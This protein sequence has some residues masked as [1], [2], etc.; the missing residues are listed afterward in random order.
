[1]EVVLRTAAEVTA[2]DA[3]GKAVV[4]VS[5]SVSSRVLGRKLAEVSNGAVILEPYA[6]DDMGMTGKV[7]ERSYGTRA[8]QKA[9]RIGGSH[10]LAAGRTGRTVVVNAPAR[11]GWG[12]PSKSAVIAAT[13]E[14]RKRSAVFGYDVGA[15]MVGAT[16]P[17][18]RVGW[19]ATKDVPTRLNADGWALFDAAV[20]WA[21]GL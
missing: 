15:V 10:P 12:V 7:A 3:A 1:M 9:V 2:A 16:A 19:F 8:G 11:F 5:E 4:I 13:L 21:S 20:R 18:R 14:D 6:L 17:G